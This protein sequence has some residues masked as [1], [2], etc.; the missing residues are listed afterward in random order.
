[1]GTFVPISIFEP[2]YL[3]QADSPE[4][5]LTHNSEQQR[6]PLLIQT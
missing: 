5:I 3:V 2:S 1:M 6:G 4:W